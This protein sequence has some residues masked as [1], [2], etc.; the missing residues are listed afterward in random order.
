MMFRRQGKEKSTNSTQ[1]LT[2]WIEWSTS[3]SKI[4]RSRTKP[5]ASSSKP[6]SPKSKCA[7]PMTNSSSRCTTSHISALRRHSIWLK[8]T[9]STS[10]RRK[11]S[12]DRTSPTRSAQ[13]ANYL[14]PVVNLRNATT[15]SL[16]VLLRT[17]RVWRMPP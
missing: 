11:I 13:T 14:K 15:R 10:R 12:F 3:S 4:A 1:P 17:L 8:S 6:R 5:I 2:T 7:R 9:W 16:S